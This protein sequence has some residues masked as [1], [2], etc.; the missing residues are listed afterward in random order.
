MDIDVAID[1]DVDGCFDSLKRVSKS[2]QVTFNG[3]EAVMAL[4]LRILK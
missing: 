1:V 2:V 4:T 3:T